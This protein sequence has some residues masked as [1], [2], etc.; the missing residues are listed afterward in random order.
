M[1]F[2]KAL[3]HLIREYAL[4]VPLE[5]FV[6]LGSFAEEVV[7]PIP[8]ALIMGTA[9]SLALMQ[10]AG[11]GYLVFLV[12]IGNIGKT[13]GSWIY[14]FLGDR[15]EDLL[16]KKIGRFFGVKH[17]DIEAIGRRFTGHHWKDGGMLFV[18]RALPFV[19]TTPVSI[20]AGIIKMD[21]RIFLVATYCGNIVKDLVYIF[22][23]YMGLAKLHTLWREIVPVKAGVDI[24]VAIGVVAFLVFLYIHRGRGKE[25]LE[26]CAARMNGR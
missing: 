15:L 18:I 13:L 11:P 26:R 10:G 2:F 12:L 25:L 3:E 16:V 17:E 5:W 4:E 7:S 8:S 6:F 23:G 21:I 20:A 9:G 14:Y 24:M 19:P 22:A 1:H